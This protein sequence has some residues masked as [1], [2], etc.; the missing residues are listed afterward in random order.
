MPARLIVFSGLDGAGKSTQLARVMQRLREAGIPSVQVWSRGGYTPGM[1]WLKQSVRRL[2]GKRMIPPAGAGARRSQS[3]SRPL[4]RRLWL[5]L[6]I[7]DLWLL[8]GVWMRFQLWRGR[9]VVADRYWQD[10]LLDFHVNFP[11]EHVERWWLWKALVWC[12][13]HPDVAVLLTIPVAESIHRS[14]VKREPFPTPPEQLE[15][16]SRHYEYWATQPDWTH[17][18]GRQSPEFLAE[19]IGA[20]VLQAIRRPRASRHRRTGGATGHHAVPHSP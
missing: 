20:G 17:F 1:E 19:A 15:R 7:L 5:S 16:R 14:Q 18:D 2:T 11:G 9:C 3:F 6:A 8:Y 13:P 12:A 10:T 4:I